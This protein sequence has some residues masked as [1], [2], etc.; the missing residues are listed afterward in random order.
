MIYHVTKKENVESIMKNGLIPQIG[1]NSI[2]VGEAK[3]Y[4]FLCEKES[5]PFWKILL[6]GDV[7][8]EIKDRDDGYSEYIEGYSFATCREYNACDVI[9]PNRISVYSKRTP[10]RK[11]HMRRLSRTELTDISYIVL[12]VIKWYDNYYDG[13][14]RKEHSLSDITLNIRS[15]RTVLQR[16]D[17]SVL[18]NKEKNEELKELGESG[19]FTFADVYFSEKTRLYKKALQFAKE[20]NDEELAKELTMLNRF[21]ERNFKLGNLYTGGW[22]F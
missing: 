17:F 11:S 1:K 9:S 8:L 7:V 18:S 4:I 2:L 13:Q 12:Q 22:C 14:F 15:L 16:I 10:V 19:E 3:P 21:I 5:I 6:E 20:N